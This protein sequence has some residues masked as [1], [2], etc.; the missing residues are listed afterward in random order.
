MFK[1]A[2]VFTRPAP[3]HQD[4]PFR[5]R[6]RNERRGEAYRG[7]YGEPL[8]DVRTKLEDFFSILFKKAR[9]A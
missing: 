8:S 2:A 6:G 1:K 9:V 5:G 7:P 3:A 4:A